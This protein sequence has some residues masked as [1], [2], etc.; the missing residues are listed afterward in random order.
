MPLKFI[1]F[2]SLFFTLAWGD[3]S[4]CLPAG[5]VD[6]GKEKLVY[7]KDTI[8]VNVYM[9]EKQKMRTTFHKSG[10]G[11]TI[12]SV[13]Y[14]NGTYYINEQ[15][16]HVTRHREESGEQTFFIYNNENHLI[17]IFSIGKEKARLYDDKGKL[18]P[19]YKE[20]RGDTVFWDP[21][22]KSDGQFIN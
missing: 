4:Y 22:Y 14:S 9:V 3:E 11:V 18:L 13:V 16:G 12:D 6:L 5:V 1:L 20:I 8:E 19:I 7:G 10:N 15:R 17:Q 2:I 21:E